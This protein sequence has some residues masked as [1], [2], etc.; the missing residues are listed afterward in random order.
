[1][2]R[3]YSSPNLFLTLANKGIGCCDTV[4][5]NMRNFPKVLKTKATNLTKDNYDYLSNGSILA[6]VWIDKRA[7]YMIT[8]IH[9]LTPS[10][11]PTVKHRKIDRTH[12]DVNS[13]PCLPD[14]QQFMRGV[15]REDQMIG[16][17]NLNRTNRANKKL[18][19]F[20]ASQLSVLATIAT[21]GHPR[22]SFAVG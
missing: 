17:Y 11:Q 5:T 8:T 15:D 7:L 6:I 22:K 18:S 2:D 16:Y 1:M 10:V 20:A 19:P 12:E 13:P 3:F 4:K 14:Y 21:A 9:T